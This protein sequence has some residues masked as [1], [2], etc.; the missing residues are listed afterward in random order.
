MPKFLVENLTDKPV[1]LGIEPWA[2][3]EILAPNGRV[4]FE[5]QE[6]A[7][8]SFALTEDGGASVSICSDRIEV[9]ANGGEKIFKQPPGWERE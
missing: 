9:T 5:Y 2:D 8:I 7:E 6:P 4:Q 1:K 3:L